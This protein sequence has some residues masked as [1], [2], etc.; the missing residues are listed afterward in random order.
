MSVG[1][2]S[3]GCNLLQKSI[4]LLYGLQ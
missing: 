1:L 4:D 3:T 2:S